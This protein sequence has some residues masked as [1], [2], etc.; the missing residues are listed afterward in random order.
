MQTMMRKIERTTQ[1]RRDFKREKRGP[2]RTTLNDALSSVL[3][4]LV[5]DQP[6]EARLGDHAMI[7]DWKGYRDCDI[8]PDLVLIYQKIGA[9]T[10]RLMRLGSYAE[11]DL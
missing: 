1:F 6:L 7:G 5:A 3:N 8:R 11:L 10:L 9:D 4:S 2:Y